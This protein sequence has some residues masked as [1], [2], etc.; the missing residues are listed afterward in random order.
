MLAIGLI[1][2]LGV[3]AL[4]SYLAYSL[5]FAVWAA[6]LVLILGVKVGV[7]IGLTSKRS[8]GARGFGIGLLL[9]IG[10]GILIFSSICGRH[11]KAFP[12]P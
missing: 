12:P 10:L 11:F 8:A 1:A 6:M 9:S 2:G 7:G 3:G 4:G 5:A